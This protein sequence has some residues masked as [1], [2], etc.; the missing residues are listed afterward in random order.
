MFDHKK[1]LKYDLTVFQ[2]IL[3]YQWFQTFN[4][5]LMCFFFVMYD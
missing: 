5:N 4:G 1:Q 3:F 2:E